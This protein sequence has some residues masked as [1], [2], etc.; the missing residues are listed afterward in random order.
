MASWVGVDGSTLAM[1]LPPAPML[2]LFLRAAADAD[3]IAGGGSTFAAFCGSASL[4]SGSSFQ[5]INILL[6][7]FQAP[8]HFFRRKGG[9]GAAGVLNFLGIACYN[10]INII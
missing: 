10:N 4:G 8:R 2:L 1:G 5:G 6:G 3:S 7:L 9:C